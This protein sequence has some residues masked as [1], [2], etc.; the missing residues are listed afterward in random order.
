MVVI[1]WLTEYHIERFKQIK[2]M[3]HFSAIIIL[4]TPDFRKMIGRNIFTHTVC[5]TH[6]QT[7]L[8]L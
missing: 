2:L 4:K 6:A 7:H 1:T 5:N 8:I 3:W